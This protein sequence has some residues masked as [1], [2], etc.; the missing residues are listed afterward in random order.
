[1]EKV[2]RKHQ[3]ITEEE[4]AGSGWYLQGWVKREEDGMTR[5]PSFERGPVELAF[6]F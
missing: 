1:M 2:E 3:I 4:T 6:R 5:S